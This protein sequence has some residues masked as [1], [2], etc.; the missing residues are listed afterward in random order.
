MQLTPAERELCSTSLRAEEIFLLKRFVPISPLVNFFSHLFI[1]VK[2]HGYLFYTLGYKPILLYLF[3]CSNRSSGGYWDLFQLHL[4]PFDP[5]VSHSR[6][7]GFYF[8]ERRHFLTLCHYEVL[9]WL[10]AKNQP[11]LQGAAPSMGE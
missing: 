4:C 3:H 8:G 7:M 6:H 2:T 1:S 11:F 10:G 5:D 9:S